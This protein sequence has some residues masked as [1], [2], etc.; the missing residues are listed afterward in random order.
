MTVDFF[1]PIVDD[2]F[3]YG[4]VAATNSLSDVYAMGAR[5]IVALNIA[6]FPEGELPADVVA[7]ILKGGATAAKEAGVVIAGGHTVKD[8]EVK[9]GLSVVGL[10]HPDE[11]IQNSG[12][13]PGDRIV[14]TKALGTGV[15]ATAH[16][17]GDLDADTYTRL[18]ASMIQLNRSAATK[19]REHGVHAATDITGYGLLGHALEMAKASGVTIAITGSAVPVLPGALDAIARGYLTGGGRT[20]RLFVG[21]DVDLGKTDEPLQN[22]LFDPQTS[23][24]LLVSLPAAEADAYVRALEADHTAAVI[25]EVTGKAATYLRVV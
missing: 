14:L 20:N 10:V 18:V 1:T 5:P 3:D 6:G 4:R 2:P 25:G 12:A 7:A 24:G 22:L 17:E 8:P 16:M 9:Y 13:R 21:D 19:M 15:L 11:I 23:G